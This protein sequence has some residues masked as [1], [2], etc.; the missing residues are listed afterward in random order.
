MTRLLKA[1]TVA[2]AVLCTVTAAQSALALSE[3]DKAQVEQIIS[4][5]LK[6]NPKVLQEMIDRLQAHNTREA[7]INAEKK[8]IAN[9][10]A[11]LGSDGAMVAGN[12]SG[13]VTVVEFF[14]YRCGYCR[15]A[16]PSMARLLEEDPDVRVV[17]KEY[18]VLGPQSITASRAAIASARQGKY[19]EF[20]MALMGLEEALNDD[21]LYR[22]AGEVGLDVAKLKQDMKDEAIDEVIAENHELAD[23]LGIE[24]T[25]N[26]II[27]TQLVQG[28]VPYETLTEYVEKARKTKSLKPVEG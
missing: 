21:V 11:V 20:H 4:D 17:F 12:P 3:R 6:N 26:F 14:D 24:G 28:M 10:V 16:Q 22:V 25:P 23:K 19:V 7:S 1:L 13:D 8:I 5:Y 2:L 18:P 9:K 27:G 15:M